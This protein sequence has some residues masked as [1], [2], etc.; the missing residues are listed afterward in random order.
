MMQ[1][2][3]VEWNLF[4]VGDWNYATNKDFIYNFWVN[5]TRRAKPYEGIFTIGMRGAGDREHMF[6]LCVCLPLMA[7]HPV[8]LSEDTNIALL[9]EIVA[10]QRVILSDV[11]NGTDITTVPQVWTLC[12]WA[13]LCTFP[14]ALIFII[15]DSEV[16]MYYQDGM[17][18]PDDV[19]L[20][21]TDDKC[22]VWILNTK[23]LRLTTF[24]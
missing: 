20:M 24:P 19:T 10:D 13:F 5:G 16:L 18:V 3:P 11:F 1:S 8:P 2:I 15:L 14:F 7:R 22:V 9:E 17:R 23:E 12:K 21:W 6:Y 4:G